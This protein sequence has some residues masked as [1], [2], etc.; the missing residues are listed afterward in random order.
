MVRYKLR[1]EKEGAMLFDNVKG[2]ITCL[3]EKQYRDVIDYN[4][5]DIAPLFDQHGVPLFSLF[6]A[7]VSRTNLPTDCLS[8]PS[9]VYFEITRQCNLK[10]VYCYNN[11]G[12]AS[13]VELDKAEIFRLLDE[14]YDLGVFE[15][16][17]TGGEP[18]LHSSF[19]EIL[20]YVKKKNFFISLASNGVWT[21]EMIQKICDSDIGIIILS[22]DGPEHYHDRGRGKGTFQAIMRTIARL[23]ASNKFILKLNTVLCKENLQYIGDV[24]QLADDL[25]INGVNFAPLRVSGRATKQ[26]NDRTPLN[27][28]DMYEAVKKITKLRDQYRVGIQTYFDILGHEVNVQKVPSSLLNKKSCAAGIEVAAISP[29]GEI[30]GC[31]VSPANETDDSCSKKFF[32]AGNINEASF[33]EIWLDSSRWKVYRDLAYNKSNNCLQCQHYT[34]RCFGNCVVD[35]YMRGGSPSAMSPLCFVDLVK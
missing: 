16:R 18:T 26:L 2:N 28:E 29:Y 17:L 23:S 7:N 5:T 24:V 19:F 4:T 27:K 1:E 21:D 14:L 3:T 32:I 25:G 8:A 35:S 10:C 33:E 30:Y 34:K 31:V 12:Q 11:S 22:I 20:E 6:K 9:K 13:N 15:I